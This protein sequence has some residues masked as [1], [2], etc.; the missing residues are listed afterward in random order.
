MG[1][2][3]TSSRLGQNSFSELIEILNYQ[4]DKNKRLE[5]QIKQSEIQTNNKVSK[6]KKEF[7]I[8]FTEQKQEIVQ[9]IKLNEKSIELNEKNAQLQK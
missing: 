1:I 6:I 3:G 5:E 7:E 2:G 8:A 9:L 4:R